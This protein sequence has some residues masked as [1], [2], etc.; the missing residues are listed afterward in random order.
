ARFHSR[1]VICD[2]LM[3]GISGLELIQRLRENPDTAGI[4]IIV[5]T[6]KTDFRLPP[7]HDSIPVIS[8]NAG[9]QSLK[10][11]IQKELG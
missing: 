11:A 2:A 1:L 3:P 4:R 8:K 5:F 10:N 9:I 7:E 6:G